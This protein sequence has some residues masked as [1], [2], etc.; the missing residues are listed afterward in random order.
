MACFWNAILKQLKRNSRD[1]PLTM[2]PVPTTPSKLVKAI[3]A[4]PRENILVSVN[5]EKVSKQ[6]ADEIYSAIE[7]GYSENNTNNGTWVS[8]FDPIL[9]ILCNHLKTDIV[10]VYCGKEIVYHYTGST[11]SDMSCLKF[12]NNK[13]HFWS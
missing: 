7:H 8:T 11:N 13:G 5:G 3:K 10:N 2:H 4:L 1:V 12:F 6:Q 9:I